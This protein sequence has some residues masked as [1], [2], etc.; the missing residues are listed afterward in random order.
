M[1]S[2]EKFKLN[3]NKKGII[4]ADNIFQLVYKIIA[5][6]YAPKV[7][8]KRRTTKKSSKAS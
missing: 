8:Y 3:V 7:K 4:Y 6:K 2:K 1:K 5:K